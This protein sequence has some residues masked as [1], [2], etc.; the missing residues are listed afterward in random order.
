MVKAPFGSL[1]GATV[2]TSLKGFCCPSMLSS[3][4]SKMIAQNL[5]ALMKRSLK[6][7]YFLVRYSHF[8]DDL[9]IYSE[10]LIYTY[11]LRMWWKNMCRA[12]FET[13]KDD[14][15]NVETDWLEN[16]HP[17]VLRSYFSWRQRFCLCHVTPACPRCLSPYSPWYFPHVPLRTHPNTLTIHPA[18]LNH[19][20]IFKIQLE[21]KCFSVKYLLRQGRREFY[22]RLIE[23]F[24]LIVSGEITLNGRV[25][26]PR[27]KCFGSWGWGCMVI[28]G[29]FCISLLPED[30]INSGKLPRHQSVYLF[31]TLKVIYL[32]FENWDPTSCWKQCT[33]QRKRWL[34]KTVKPPVGGPLSHLSCPNLNGKRLLDS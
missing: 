20:Y 6:D 27:N 23:Y 31:T 18:S 34:F 25:I 22:F 17:S 28:D 21:G 16:T 9:Q 33:F 2:I 8:Q 29:A 12:L 3:H 1:Q 19:N 10:L 5:S 24:L 15:S 30:L 11:H 13:L 7:I 4:S 14:T 26:P 32:T